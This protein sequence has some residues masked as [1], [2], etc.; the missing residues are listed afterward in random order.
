VLQSVLAQQESWIGF[1]RFGM[2]RRHKIKEI[3]DSC[4]NCYAGG[5]E[6]QKEIFA[7]IQKA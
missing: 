2:S 3:N 6:T 5:E 4:F 1:A 7:R